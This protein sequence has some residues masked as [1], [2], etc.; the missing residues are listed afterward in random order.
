MSQGSVDE[1][2]REPASDLLCRFQGEVLNF[3]GGYFHSFALGN[4]HMKNCF[5][6]G[7][8]LPVVR[9]MMG[10]PIS[11]YSPEKN[12]LIFCLHETLHVP[13]SP[14]TISLERL[15]NG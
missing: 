13:H 14:T 8:V 11:F 5:F 6:F 15:K 10:T 2:M 1:L 9:A 3:V 12:W 7:R 4:F